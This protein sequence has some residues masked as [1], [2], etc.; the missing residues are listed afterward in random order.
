[1][2]IDHGWCRSVYTTDPTGILVEWC[3]T[4]RVFTDEDRRDAARDLADPSPQLKQ[5]PE[6][7]FH[8]AADRIPASN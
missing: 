7:V 6:P 1:M 5:P 2:E 3:T 4:T 8:R